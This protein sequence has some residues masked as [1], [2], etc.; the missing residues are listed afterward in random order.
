MRVLCAL[1]LV[2]L[3]GG[4]AAASDKG[5]SKL[6]DQ[7]RKAERKGQIIEAYLLYSQAAARDPK[8]IEY[9]LRAQGLRVKA[10]LMATEKLPQSGIPV[11]EGPAKVGEAPAAREPAIEEP[12]G[13]VALSLAELKPSP[14]RK[15]LDL[16]GDAR[17]LFTLVAKLYRLDADFDTDYPTSGTAFPFRLSDAGWQDAIRGL[18]A[19]T[20]SFVLPTSGRRFLV[21]KDT[22]QK[23]QEREPYI[24]VTIPIPDTIS[25]Q[26]TQ[27]LT[28]AVR[29]VAQLTRMGFDMTRR[30]IVVRDRAS[31]VLPA[32]ALI[33]QLLRRRTMVSIE[34][35]L[36]EA[37]QN[38]STSYGVSLPTS[39]PLVY[40]GGIL[41]SVATI[42]SGFTN[43]L[44]FGGGKTLFGFGLVS[45]QA[46]AT[47]SRA[48][49]ETLFQTT[50]RS[51][52]GMPASLLVG[53]KYPIVTA[54]EIGSTSTTP[55]YPTSFTF[56]DLGL[57]VKATP[58][59]HGLDEMTLDLETSFKALTS[60]VID[61]IPVISNRSLQ[62]RVRLKN[63]EWSVV[64]GLMT[65]SQA[66]SISGLAGLSRV[67]L[68]RE[69]LS[70]RTRD[71]NEKQ[72]LLLIRPTLVSLPPG[73]MPTTAIPAGSE[74]R[75]RIPL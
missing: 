50:L 30:T 65:S 71:D 18:E 47:M 16:R 13:P 61:E 52:D 8:T 72:V 14:E 54:K 6:Y 45:A 7:A 22:P 10:T 32:Q 4:L 60:E 40:F 43:F 36:V 24:S 15:D 9:W 48:T 63:A 17:T 57:T 46:V 28:N 5:A 58:H 75:P 34:V 42:P 38:L 35:E 20:S 25:A 51:L 12:P 67:P 44:T 26:E 74:T 62:T 37:D 68:L 41:R 70:Q 1:A 3:A 11:P 56:V 29:T 66:K 39:F 31:V 33:Q 27:E 2:W 59:V 53:E 21:V 69:I 73:E 19:A 55:Y 23:R 64:A 49:G